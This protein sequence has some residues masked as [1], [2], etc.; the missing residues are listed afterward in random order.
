MLVCLKE[1]ETTFFL[2]TFKWLLL[3]TRDRKVSLHENLLKRI[4]EKNK[5][6]N[7]KDVNNIKKNIQFISFTLFY[8][9]FVID[10]EFWNRKVC[11]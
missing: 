4:S 5:Q 9:K 8:I 2:I 7:S 3:V 1:N 6:C 11:F 10:L